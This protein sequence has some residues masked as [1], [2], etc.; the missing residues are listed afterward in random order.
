MSNLR[1]INETTF[2]SV[3]TVN[4]TDVFS[5]DFDIYKITYNDGG[6]YGLLKFINSAGSVM[7]DATYD[8]ARQNLVI[9]NTSSETKISGGTDGL[10]V[11]TESSSADG[12][13]NVLY[14]F[15]PFSSSSY[16]FVIA[17][18]VD[19]YTSSNHRIAKAIGVHKNTASMGG[20]QLNAL[21]GVDGTLRT[22]G[23]RVD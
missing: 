9:N 13:G 10:Y 6:Q 15:N 7:S 23:L 11:F 17:Q 16:T 21:A 19:I 18:T 8:T 12:G 3:N 20:F 14:V 1:L 5:A 22:Y 4:V 2:S